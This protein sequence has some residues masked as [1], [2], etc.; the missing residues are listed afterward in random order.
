MNIVHFIEKIPF[1]EIEFLEE[2]AWPYFVIL[3]L[4]DAFCTYRMYRRFNE[5]GWQCLIPFYNWK[6]CFE[7][8]WDLKAFR[9]HLFLEVCGFVLPFIDVSFHSEFLVFLF[10]LLD[11]A[12]ACLGLRHGIE[13]GIF[14]LRSFGYDVKRYL[15]SIFFFD[16]A[17][18]LSLKGKY[19]GNFSHHH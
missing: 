4:I 14:T 12:V 10:S 19:Q 18:I 9:E 7:H 15:W 13:I 3:Y 16:F 17:L 1:W 2:I 6:V 11:I 8:C 5:P